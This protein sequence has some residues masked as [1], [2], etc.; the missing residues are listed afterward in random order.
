MNRLRPTPGRAA[1]RRPAALR[2]PALRAGIVHLG[3]GAFERAHLAAAT[4]AAM[5]ASG[6]LRWGIVGV[7][8]RSAD[9]RDALA[10]QDGLY[11]L[12]LRDAD[13]QGQPRERLQVLG[14]L[15]RR[16]RRAR[17]PAGGAGAHRR[18]RTRA[19]SA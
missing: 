2:P 11:T 18:R 13:A 17:R 5:A 16:A 9:M 4:E 6:D 12:A 15:L 1:G 14:A 7:S 19:S 10:P 8:L 3:L